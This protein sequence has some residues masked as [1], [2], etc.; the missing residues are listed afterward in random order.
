MLILGD[1]LSYGTGAKDGEY[2]PTL[3]ASEAKACSDLLYFLLDQSLLQL[4]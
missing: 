2:Y 3:L 4:P 1:S